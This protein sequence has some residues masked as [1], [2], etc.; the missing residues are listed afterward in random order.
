MQKL[1]ECIREGAKKRPQAFGDY[2]Q[3]NCTCALGAAYEAITNKMPMPD[4]L[5]DGMVKATI[6]S[7]TGTKDCNV[8]YPPGSFGEGFRMHPEILDLITSLNDTEHWT[9]EHIAGYLESIGY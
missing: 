7:A 5:D 8:P 4:G 2:I 3:D 6:Y 9:R 1:S